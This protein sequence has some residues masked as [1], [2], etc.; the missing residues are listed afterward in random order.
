MSIG[1]SAPSNSIRGRKSFAGEIIR[2]RDREID[3]G[4]LVIVKKIDPGL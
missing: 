1:W 4:L 3:S 2:R